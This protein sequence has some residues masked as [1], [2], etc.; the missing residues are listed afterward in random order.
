SIIPSHGKIEAWARLSELP[1]EH[2]W[3]QAADGARLFEWYVEA[4]ADCPVILWSHDN[5][6]RIIVDWRTCTSSIGS[7][8][9]F[10][11]ST[12]RLRRESG[13]AIRGRL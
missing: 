2:V 12:T 8:R 9:Q 3:F 5:L 10:L 11:S 6:G 1:L 4:P 7:D 13:K